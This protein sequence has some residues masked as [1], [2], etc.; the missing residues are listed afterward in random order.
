MNFNGVAL[1][2]FAQF[3]GVTAF[4]T[5]LV[6]PNRDQSKQIWSYEVLDPGQNPS[7]MGMCYPYPG[8]YLPVGAATIATDSALAVFSPPFHIK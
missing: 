2:Y 1:A 5:K 4:Y 3:S 8:Y 6:D 7:T